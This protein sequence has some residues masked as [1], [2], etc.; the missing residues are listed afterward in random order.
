MKYYIDC[1]FDGLDGPLL[2]MALASETGKSMYVVMNYG[3]IRDP[4]VNAN[5]HPIMLDVPLDQISGPV[6]FGADITQLS[7]ALEVFLAGDEYVYVIAD[8]PDDIKY[9][10]DAL[11]TGPGTMIDIP[12]VT[13]AVKRVDV[14]PTGLPGA[15][16]HNAWWDAMALRHFFRPG[17]E[18]NVK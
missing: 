3:P 9:F 1:E 11:I 5:V 18:E 4:W 7:Q 16:Q 10:A 2:S 14:Y 6:V 15:V 8:W 13:F 17:G 12:R